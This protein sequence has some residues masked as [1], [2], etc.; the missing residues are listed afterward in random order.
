MKNRAVFSL[1]LAVLL[2]S[3][4]CLVST[5]AAQEVFIQEGFED[6]AE[7]A[8]P[9]G[10]NEGFEYATHTQD[11]PDFGVTTE[12]VKTGSKSLKAFGPEK[13][14]Y[15]GVPMPKQVPV[16]SVEFWYY[17]VEGG[18]GFTLCVSPAQDD[19]KIYTGATYIVFLDGNVCGWHNVEG[20]PGNGEKVPLV[21]YETGKWS[22]L[23]VVVD[24]VSQTFDL[25][26]G[27]S[28]AAVWDRPPDA[29]NYLNRNPGDQREPVCTWLAFWIFDTATVTY[30]DDLLVYSGSEPAAADPAGKF[31]TL[32]GEVKSGY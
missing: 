32:W 22:Y 1:V 4:A 14:W 5:A 29:D 31:A 23:R 12:I 10:W 9:E 21:P 3:G 11:I 2:A 13:S 20:Q 26:G 28:P 19:Q 30:V 17:V 8:L 27:D 6:I 18:R 25:W 7:G 16:V 15:G 24:F